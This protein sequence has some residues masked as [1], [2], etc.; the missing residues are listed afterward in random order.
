MTLRSLKWA[1]IT[2]GAAVAIAVG[3]LTGVT[4]ASA[5][6]SCGEPDEDVCSYIPSGCAQGQAC[7]QQICYT[8][9]CLF[10]QSGVGSRC[11]RCGNP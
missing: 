3:A 5:A 9:F 2:A 8:V 4:S 11:W 1:G 10:G 7:N 6:E